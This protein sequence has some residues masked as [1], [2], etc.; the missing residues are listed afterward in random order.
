MP[1]ISKERVEIVLKEC[2]KAKMLNDAKQLDY[3]TGSKEWH[4]HES[5]D[6]CLHEIHAAVETLGDD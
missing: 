2:K 6:D 4:L 5:I 1:N 3:K